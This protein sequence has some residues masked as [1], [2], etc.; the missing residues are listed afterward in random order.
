MRDAVDDGRAALNILQSH[1]AGTGKL[2]IILLYTELTSLLKGADESVTDYIIKAERAAT[3]LRNAGETVSDSL[4]TAMTMKGLPEEYKPFVVVITR[5][6]KELTF[7]EFRAML[8]SYEETEKA[9]PVGDDTVMNAEF[10]G[11]CYSCGKP[12]HMSRDCKSK[13]PKYSM[14]CSFCKKSNHTDKSYRRK[15]SYDKELRRGSWGEP[16]HRDDTM[17]VRNEE[18]DEHSFAF[19]I[20]FNDGSENQAGWLLVDCGATAH[21]ITDESC[22]TKFDGTFRPSEHY[23]ELADGSRA[24]NVALK[25]RD[26]VVTLQDKKG[27]LV[28]ATLQN[29][30]YI[31]SYPQNIFSV[32][33]ATEKGATV[34]LQKGRSWMTAADGTKF[35]IVQRGRLYYFENAMSHVNDDVTHVKRHRQKVSVSRCTG[36]VKEPCQSPKV[37]T[38]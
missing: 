25:R 34:T 26:A 12:G 31:P 29:T 28:E 38:Y 22:F 17:C 16:G 3:A 27:R 6:E 21:I 33:A 7:R 9:R 20:N 11:H 37:K 4:L 14:W 10:K 36:F 8:R 30:L 18:S 19:K 2:R 15:K 32:Q 5:R 1:Y 23:V 13:Q 35:I 24:N